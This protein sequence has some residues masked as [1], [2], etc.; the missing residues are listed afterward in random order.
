MD[1]R[2]TKRWSAARFAI[3]GAVVLATKF[4]NVRGADGAFLGINGKPDTSGR[5]VTHR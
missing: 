3:G 1:L 5:R 2:P 4:G